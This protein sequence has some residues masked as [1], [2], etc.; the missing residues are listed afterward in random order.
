MT[1]LAETRDALAAALGAQ[2]TEEEARLA[3]EAGERH[4]L[5]RRRQALSVEAL[6]GDPAAVAELEQIEARLGELQRQERL[7]DL[8]QAEQQERGQQAAAEAA[9][10]RRRLLQREKADTEAQRDAILIR[11]EKAIGTLVDLIPQAVALDQ[12][13]ETIGH[14]IDSGYVHGRV[15][16]A[17]DHRL[18][19]RLREIGIRDLVP[20]FNADR[21][22]CEPLAV[23][24]PKPRTRRS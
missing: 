23:A 13:V 20:V 16:R 22:G 2:E 19:R 3:A 6:A 12:Q 11:L 24:K 8:A 4:E 9:A 10:Q 5:E 14:Q 15:S 17:I 18:S 21:E 7:R 1:E